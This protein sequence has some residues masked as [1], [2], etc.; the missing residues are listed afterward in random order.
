MAG[1]KATRLC[2]GV[3]EFLVGESPKTWNCLGRNS[4]NNSV[5]SRLEASKKKNK[6]SDEVLALNEKKTNKKK[7]QMSL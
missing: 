6:T 1:I 7:K 2:K 3:C 4:G 5:F